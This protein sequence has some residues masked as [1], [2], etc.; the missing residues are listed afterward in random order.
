V[1]HANILVVGGSGFVGRHLVAAL[2]ARGARVTVP[3]RRRDRARHLILLP[4]VDVVEADLRDAGVLAGLAAG[5]DAVVNLAGVLHGPDFKRTHVELA[6]AV[7]NACR[8]AGVGRL[9]HMSALGADPEA[10]SEYL[11]SKGVGERAVLAADDLQVSVFRPSVIFG[12]EDRFLNLFAQLSALFPVLALGMPEARFQPVYVGDVVKAMLAALDDRAHSSGTA[13]KRYDLGGPRE[14]TLRELMEFVCAVTGRRRL[15]VGLPDS[16]AWLQAWTME[17][18]PV[19]LLTRDNLRS[20][21]VPSV[22]D[23]PFPFGIHPVALEATAPAWLAPSGPRER[24]PELRWKA[25]R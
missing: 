16:L 11:R 3:T 20:M 2:A 12:P 24:Y 15:I 22:C 8:S 13:G 18:L 1:K 14:W 17:L 19:K 7:V 21:R 10:P 25:R 23:A 6:Q 4:T 5:R 9:L